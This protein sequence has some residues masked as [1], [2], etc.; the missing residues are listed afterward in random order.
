MRG[1]EVST[2]Y[3]DRKGIVLDGCHRDNGQTLIVVVGHVKEP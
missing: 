2:G 3:R 1:H